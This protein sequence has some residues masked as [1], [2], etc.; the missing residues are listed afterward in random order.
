[1][2]KLGNIF[3]GNTFRITQ[4]PHGKLQANTSFD[5]TGP[6]GD[7]RVIAPTGYSYWTIERVYGS[8]TQR[9]FHLVSPNRKASILYHHA[10]PYKT[11]KVYPNQEIGKSAWH[12]I[13]ASIK[14][15]GKWHWLTDYFRRDL[16][17]TTS[18][19]GKNSKWAKWSTY[20]TNLQLPGTL[21]DNNS[22][23]NNNSMG[24]IKLQIKMKPGAGTFPVRRD[25]NDAKS[26]IGTVKASEILNVSA[27]ANGAE[28]NGV[29]HHFQL[30]YYKPDKPSTHG[31]WVSGVD[32]DKYWNPNTVTD[33][34]ISQ[35]D[36][37]K[38]VAQLQEVQAKIQKIE[39]DY[40]ALKVDYEV[41]KEENQTFI[42]ENSELKNQVE[43][44][45][46][47]IKN[48]EKQLESVGSTPPTDSGSSAIAEAIN[49][50]KDAILKIF[51]KN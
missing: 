49:S 2:A 27:V 12:H 40:N 38:V 29:K 9:G 33:D 1:M 35:A 10:H 47:E 37:D 25:P 23:S 24:D 11:G 19:A 21:P 26:V 51:G 3:H 31:G 7:L 22:N 42:D 28:W 15:N 39:S 46:K 14:V 13:H 44:Q 8:G 6:N 41:L 48:L 45:Q 36:V 16:T 17:L 5:C 4:S 30:V 50:L 43:E 32:V 18:W 20:T 34:G